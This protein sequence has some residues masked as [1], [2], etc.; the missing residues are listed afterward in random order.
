MHYSILGRCWDALAKFAVILQTCREVAVHAG[1]ASSRRK[2]NAGTRF[3]LA[4]IDSAFGLA[5]CRITYHI[6]IALQREGGFPM[7]AHNRIR[8]MVVSVPAPSDRF[9]D[10]GALSREVLP[11]AD[12]YVAGLIAKLQDEVRR[13]RRFQSLVRQTRPAPADTTGDGMLYV[14]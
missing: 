5:G 4:F 12:P 11:W 2:R 10:R 3:N 6:D 9:G 1:R 13:E 7:V 8:C 14:Q